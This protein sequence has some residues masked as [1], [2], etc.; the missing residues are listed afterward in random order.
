MKLMTVHFR[1][2]IHLDSR[3]TDFTIPHFSPEAGTNGGAGAGGWPPSCPMIYSAMVVKWQT[4]I[5]WVVINDYKTA[6]SS[7]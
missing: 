4:R 5:T 3:C 1:H 2:V 6:T 7:C